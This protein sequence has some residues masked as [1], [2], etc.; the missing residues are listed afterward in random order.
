MA[1]RDRSPRRLKAP[2]A[3]S[4]GILAL[5]IA[6]LFG[7]GDD[8]PTAPDEQR[9]DGLEFTGGVDVAESFPVQLNFHLRVRNTTLRTLHL[10]SDG[11]GMLPRAYGDPARAGEP[12]WDG[13]PGGPCLASV[14]PITF[15][16]GETR[17]FTRRYSARDILGDSLP[18][19]RYFFT[20]TYRASLAPDPDA[21]SRLVE[22]AA[23][24]A[25][26]ALP[27]AGRSAETRAVVRPK[28][29]DG[30]RSRGWPSQDPVPQASSELVLSDWDRR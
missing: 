2:G 18:D 22:V 30:A 16:P 6:G 3:T 11:C 14:A 1:E 17:R 15:A 7:C 4:A 10:V 8:A 28:T 5:L 26:L 12:V 23:G 9:L 20:V 27:P 24:E 29:P 19:G 13:R 25:E 21:E